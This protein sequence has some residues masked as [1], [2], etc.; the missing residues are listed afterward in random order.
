MPIT[1]RP[2]TWND[3]EPCLAIQPSNRGDA[4]SDVKS[5]LES[6]KRLFEAPFSSSI[7]LE[8]SPAI[9]GYGLIGFGSAVLVSTR[10]TDAEVAH[11]RPDIT[12]RIMA[13]LHSGASVLASWDE[14]AR[15]NAGDGV[16]VVIVYVAWRDNILSPAE[17]HDVEELFPT[18]FADNFAGFRIRRIVVETTSEPVT[19]F[20]R[21]SLEYQV[22]AEFSD[23]GRVIHLMTEESATVLPGSF[24]NVIFKAYQPVLRLRNSDQQLL[25]AA[26]KGATD[27]ELAVQLGI[28]LS[29]VKARWRSTIAR[30][31]EVM[32]DL[33][34]DT[35]Y[36]KGRGAQKRHRVLAYLRTH[37]EELRP[38]DW[39][40][41]LRQPKQQ[42]IAKTPRSI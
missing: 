2:A 35:E 42:G 1:W 19:H 22:I 9:Q 14:I 28:T 21:R 11:P 16:D 10:F 24:G 32:P 6:W 29:A 33:V 4:C 25:L 8:S 34:I 12:S 13:S 27:N 18:S 23:I 41:K 38:Y 7:V 17:R 20:H 40:A 5:A 37:M 36:R 3:I 15:A 26:L 30:I 39:K 31:E